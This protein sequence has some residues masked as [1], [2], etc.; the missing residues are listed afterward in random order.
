LSTES[1]LKF[2]YAIVLEGHRYYIPYV[3]PGVANHALF[4]KIYLPI[5]RPQA[6]RPH[7]YKMDS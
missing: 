6:N 1:D 7:K 2:S 4:P 5:S 3:D